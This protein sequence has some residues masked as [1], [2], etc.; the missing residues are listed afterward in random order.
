MTVYMSIKPVIIVNGFI[1]LHL[2]SVSVSPL[3]VPV[4]SYPARILVTQIIS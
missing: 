3:S 4:L 2:P 1:Q